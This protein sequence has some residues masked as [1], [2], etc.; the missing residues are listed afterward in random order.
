MKNFLA[1]ALI[2][3]ASL[4]APAVRASGDIL[5]RPFLEND[6]V[7]FKDP[8]GK[9]VIAPKYDGAKGTW[10]GLYLPYDPKKPLPP[11]ETMK[12]EIRY[13]PNGLCAVQIGPKWGFIDPAGKVQINPVYKTVQPFH[14]GLA[15]AR[16]ADDWILINPSGKEVR[17]LYYDDISE[18]WLY[19]RTLAKSDIYYIFIDGDYKEVG[20]VRFTEVGKRVDDRT[21]VEDMSSWGY[22]DRSC[23]LV[24]KPAFSAA[25]HFKGERACAA[26]GDGD[27][28]RWGYID[29]AG[30][31]VIPPQFIEAKD[32][33][34]GLAPVAMTRLTEEI[35]SDYGFIGEDGKF[36]IDP[37]FVDAEPFSEGLAA[38]MFKGPGGKGLGKWG[39][40]DKEGK[41]VLPPKYTFTSNFSQGVAGYT[42]SPDGLWG[43]IDKQ[44]KVVVKPIFDNAVLLDFQDGKTAVKYKGKYVYIDPKGKVLGPA[45]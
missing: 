22:I 19:G 25:R 9:V 45:Q 43:L 7:G 13:F 8:A 15:I 34:E 18:D 12:A 6:K 40:I 1:V 3:L 26:M 39:F 24:I 35:V 11:F 10:E 17:K 44:G 29:R 21:P 37:D 5:L 30:K 14:K 32:F 42:L 23:K 36:V 31:F 33:S 41:T 28:K 4:A 16:M 38:V 2:L 20:D 27:E